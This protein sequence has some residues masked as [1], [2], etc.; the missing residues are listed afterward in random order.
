MPFLHAV[1][2]ETLRA[3]LSK[4]P[5]SWSMAVIRTWCNLWLASFQ[6]SYLA[7][8]RNCM[9]GCVGRRGRLSHYLRCPVLIRAVFSSLQRPIP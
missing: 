7:G 9:F 1:D 6:M 3:L 8:K 2:W 4:C 5:C